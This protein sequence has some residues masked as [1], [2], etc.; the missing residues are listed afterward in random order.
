M[1][2]AF[3]T[4]EIGKVIRIYLAEIKPVSEVRARVDLLGQVFHKEVEKERVGVRVQHSDSLTDGVFQER[5]EGEPVKKTKVLIIFK[6]T[7]R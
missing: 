4:S 6:S 1:V 2:F 5:V 3:S 7:Q